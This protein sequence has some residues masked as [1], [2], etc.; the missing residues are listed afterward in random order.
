MCV[1]V[2]PTRA[3]TYFIF[4][5]HHKIGALEEAGKNLGTQSA[6]HIYEQS[7]GIFA[8][9]GPDINEYRTLLQNIKR[10]WHL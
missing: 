5:K 7:P 1:Q 4:R 9:L 8:I 2:C 6:K 10:T 3:R